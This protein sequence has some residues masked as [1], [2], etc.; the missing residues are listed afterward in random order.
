MARI[1][2]DDGR[3]FNLELQAQVFTTGR[4]F[5][6]QSLRRI[7]NY[8]GGDHCCSSRLQNGATLAQ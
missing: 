3:V 2:E 8:P 7:I 1:V 6:R 4:Y 5:F